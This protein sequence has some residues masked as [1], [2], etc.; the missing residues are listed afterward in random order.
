[1]T[2]REPIVRFIDTADSWT[3][4]AV[5]VAVIV[6]DG[7]WQELLV[8]RAEAMM[9]LRWSRDVVRYDIRW[10]IEEKFRLV[11]GRPR[12]RTDKNHARHLR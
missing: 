9:L 8:Q 4:F 6:V 1:M 11:A 7:I 3:R 2:S 12:E 10:A 5:V